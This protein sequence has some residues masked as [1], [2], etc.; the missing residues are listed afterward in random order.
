MFTSMGT[1]YV[2]M[3]APLSAT[4]G[5]GCGVDSACALLADDSSSPCLAALRR[6]CKVST[7]TVA[8]Q[9]RINTAAMMIAVV[10]SVDMPVLEAPTSSVAVVDDTV[11]IPEPT[12]TPEPL[13][14]S[15]SAAAVQRLGAMVAVWHTSRESTPP[16]P[17]GTKALQDLAC[18]SNRELQMI[19][20]S[21]RAP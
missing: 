4:P 6:R 12:R 5:V 7:P 8:R 16:R 21:Q 9:R 11:G 3:S 19:L 10:V 1:A 18:A 20:E 17:C 2:L 13:F 15:A 14:L